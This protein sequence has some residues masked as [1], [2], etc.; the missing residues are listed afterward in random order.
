MN[1]LSSGTLYRY[2]ALKI[3]E[4]KNSYNQKFINKISRS[5]SLKK[6]NNKKLYSPDV[7]VL[8]SLIAKK[9]FVRNALKGFQKNFIKKSK[10]VIVEGRDIGSKIMPNA[11][12]KLFFRC[13]VKEK[14]KRRLKEFR[15]QNNKITLKQV[16]KALIQRDKEDIKRKISPL[17]ITKNAVLV[18]TSKLSIKQMEAKLVNLVKESINNKYGNL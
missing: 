2:C 11:D 6:L 7:A 14:A 12:L 18:D 8:S 1:F 10:L 4:N 3:I 13:S 9:P 15:N 16:E 17:I 5:I